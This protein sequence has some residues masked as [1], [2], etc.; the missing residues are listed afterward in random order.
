MARLRFGREPLGDVHPGDH[1][2]ADA[3]VGGAVRQHPPQVRAAIVGAGDRVRAA[4]E[5]S[6]TLAAILEQRGIGDPQARCR[7][8]V[9][10]G[11]SAAGSAVWP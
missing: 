6:S 1:H 2:A 11:R 4:S 8:T 10:R 9:G 7:E 3:V 5:L